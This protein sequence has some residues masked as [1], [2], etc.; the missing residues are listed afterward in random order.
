[1]NTDNHSVA[2]DWDL[3]DFVSRFLETG[4]QMEASI[5][6]EAGSGNSTDPRLSQ[7]HG[8]PLHGRHSPSRLRPSLNP[9]AGSSGYA[10]VQS[11]TASALQLH[12]SELPV[13]AYLGKPAPWADQAL[14]SHSK[15][16]R[17]TL[18]R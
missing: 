5:D 7:A 11:S 15:V 17:L 8:N 2:S 14:Q 12:S 10:G 1:M 16:V 3:S 13:R 4:R 6:T 18:A 9:T